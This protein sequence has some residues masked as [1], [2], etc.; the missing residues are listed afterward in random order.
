VTVYRLVGRG[1]IEEK[2]VKMHQEK[3]DL[4]NSLL[5]GTDMSARVTADDLLK[6]IR[7]EEL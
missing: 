1:T 3:R 5:E 7:E 2:I 6:L 4:A